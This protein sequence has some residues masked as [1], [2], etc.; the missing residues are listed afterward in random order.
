MAFDAPPC[1]L[2]SAWMYGIEWMTDELHDPDLLFDVSDVI[3]AKQN[4]L[5]G[6]RPIFGPDH[7]E[8]IEINTAIARFWGIRA[9]VRYAEPLY[10]TWGSMK[11]AQLT[12][13]HYNV[14]QL[15]LAPA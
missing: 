7:E 5:R 13:D 9:G 14:R 10:Q 4:S 3:E 6:T 15:P 12:R 8:Q 11:L 1:R 2:L